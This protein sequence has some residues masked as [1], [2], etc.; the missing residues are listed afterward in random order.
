MSY[1]AGV[2]VPAEAN[3]DY[4]WNNTGTGSILFEFANLDPGTYDVSVFEGRTTD[5]NGQFGK[6]WVG[7]LGGEPGSQNTGDFA[8]SS[9]TLVGLTIGAGDSL[10][11]RH[12]EDNIGGTSGL[13]VRPTQVA[14]AVPEP[15]SFG[16]ATLALLGLALFGRRRR[17]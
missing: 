15:G 7:A 8:G 13:I 14:A 1:V 5:A 6:I 16:L 3:N 2:G 17:R 4:V 12:L 9:S 10:F 11:Y